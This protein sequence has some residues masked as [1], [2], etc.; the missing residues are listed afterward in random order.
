MGAFE[1]RLAAALTAV[2]HGWPV[3]PLR[4]LGKVPALKDW[5]RRA[6]L[7][8]KQVE[9][10]WRHRP[11]NIGISCRA[12][13]LLVVDLDQGIPHGRDVLADLARRY[14]ADD[15]ADTYTVFTPSGGEHRYFRAPQTPL[16]NTVGKLG[17]HVDTRSAGGYVAAAGSIRHMTSGL[18]LY[19]VIRDVPPAPAPEWLVRLL[20]PP[21][22]PPPPATPSIPAPRR[23]RAYRAAALDGEAQR[24]RT[25]VPGTRAHALFTAACRLGELVGAGW[26]DEQDATATLLNAAAHHNGVEGWTDREARHHITNGLATGRRSPRVIPDRGVPEP[27][28]PAPGRVGW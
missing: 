4:P 14:G 16:R 13:D 17:R 11:Y 10:W 8:V 1:A 6:T 22:P 21:P 23:V 15:P 28:E 2:E 19:K 3:F 7:D 25:A 18:R 5:D 27:R 24:V 9:A 26:L 12:A 20:S